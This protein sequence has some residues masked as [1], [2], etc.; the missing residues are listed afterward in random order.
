MNNL[1]DLSEK[2]IN[3]ARQILYLLQSIN[4]PLTNRDKILITQA[5]KNNNINML[6]VWCK[7]KRTLTTMSVKEL[8]NVASRNNIEDYC[9]MRKEELIHAINRE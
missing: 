6:K 8:R 2:E 7:S 4:V 5:I 9:W 1:I 3:K